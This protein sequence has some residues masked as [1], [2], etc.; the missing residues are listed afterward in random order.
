[1]PTCPTCGEPTPEG[2]FCV[3]CGAPLDEE[4]EHAHERTHY[5]AAPGEHRYAPWLV[6]TLFPAPPR[7]SE[8]HFHEALGVGTAVVVV[9][10]ALRLFPVALITAALLMPLLTVL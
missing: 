9:L 8:R 4:L 3:R 5:A 7:R 6:S 2:N 1:M 10:A